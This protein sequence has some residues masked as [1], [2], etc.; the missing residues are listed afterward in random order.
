MTTHAAMQ[1]RKNITT[2]GTVHFVVDGER[3]YK[4]TSA[5]GY[6]WVKRQGAW[7]R[8]HPGATL[9]RVTSAVRAF[10]MA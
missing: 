2:H 9:E 6:V 8:L 4:V 1:V 5:C 7:R 3:R 10:A